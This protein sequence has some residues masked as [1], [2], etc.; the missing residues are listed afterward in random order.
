MSLRF[1]T[2]SVH[3]YLDY[4]VAVALMTL[5]FLLGLGQ[6]N[7]LALWLSVATGVAAFVLTVLTD[8]HLGI[9]R[10]LPYRFHLA[11]DLLVGVTFLFAP[12]IFGFTG[13][14]AAF[15]WLNGAAVVLVI[16]LS[17]PEQDVAA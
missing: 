9:W 15:Y 7:P 12:S 16:S 8:H 11:V 13:M 1:V 2:R 17:A 14:D 4:P 6:S 10:V 5:P 3:A